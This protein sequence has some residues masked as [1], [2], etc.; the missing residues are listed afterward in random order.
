MTL[1]E[2]Q[3]IWKAE[4]LSGIAERWLNPAS[5][6]KFEMVPAKGE[7]IWGFFRDVGHLIEVVEERDAKHKKIL[8]TEE[9][10]SKTEYLDEEI[11]SF[12]IAERGPGTFEQGTPGRGIKMRKPILLGTER[13]PVEP[14][15]KVYVL[16]LWY[17]NFVS[18]GCWALTLGAMNKRI[19][20]L[21]NL[22]ISYGWFFEAKGFHLRYEG[23][24]D[25]QRQDAKG[26][27]KYYGR[28]LIYWV[29][30]QKTF[31]IYEKTLD[32][33]IIELTTAKE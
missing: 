27:G 20:W 29:R 8:Y 31:K 5:D 13:D 15:Y 10:G 19:E 25:A 1:G 3:E 11:I 18:L 28:P 16:Q 33:L 22:M 30:S 21:E 6:T 2:G 7:D 14:Q 23:L 32:Q 17:D 26:G 9:Y 4:I 12:E 24:G